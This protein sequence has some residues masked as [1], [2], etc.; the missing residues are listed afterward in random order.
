ML[1]YV[2]YLYKNIIINYNNI[3][4]IFYNIYSITYDAYVTGKYINVFRHI[5]CTLTYY[6]MYNKSYK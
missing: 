5:L 2:S 1:F 3:I 6:N 4:G